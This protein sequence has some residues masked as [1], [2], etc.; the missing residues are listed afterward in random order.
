MDGSVVK[1][2]GQENEMVVDV[3]VFVMEL[4][5]L[6]KSEARWMVVGYMVHLMGV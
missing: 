3:L 1:L 4:L 6:E 5:P 2:K